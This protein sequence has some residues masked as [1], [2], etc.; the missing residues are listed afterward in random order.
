MSQTAFVTGI[1][2]ALSGSIDLDLIFYEP[3]TK[4]LYYMRAR[5][6]SNNVII[7]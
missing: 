2:D 7:A 4:D 1:A 3:D 5:I 6:G